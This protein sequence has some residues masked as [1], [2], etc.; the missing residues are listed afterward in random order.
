MNDGRA[1]ASRYRFLTMP[2]SSDD[3][4]Y[5]QSINFHV[6]INSDTQISRE[7]AIPFLNPLV[8]EQ[9]RDFLVVAIVSAIPRFSA[10]FGLRDPGKDRDESI[11]FPSVR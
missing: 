7:I 1:R 11:F 6:G 5:R 10:P 8:R 9:L 3:R 2:E 4:E